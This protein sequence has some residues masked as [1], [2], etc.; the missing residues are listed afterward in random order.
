MAVGDRHG[1]GHGPRTVN[2]TDTDGQERTKQE[3]Y[4]RKTRR[5]VRNQHRRRAER[6]PKRI[7]KE[8]GRLS[9]SAKSTD[10]ELEALVE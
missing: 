7:V 9:V 4:T 5:E 8:A 1:I 10:A 3:R 6:K 2:W